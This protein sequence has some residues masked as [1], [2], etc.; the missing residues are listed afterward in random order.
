[1]KNNVHFLVLIELFTSEYHL[2]CTRLPLGFD[3]AKALLGGKMWFFWFDF[4]HFSFMEMANQLV[5]CSMVL[6]SSLQIAVSAIYAKYSVSL[7]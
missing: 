1:M 3:K 6:P 4:L 7:A 5:H 2:D